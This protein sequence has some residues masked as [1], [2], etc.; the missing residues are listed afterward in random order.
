MVNTSGRARAIAVDGPIRTVPRVPIWSGGG[1]DG[2]AVLEFVASVGSVFT[3]HTKEIHDLAR[4]VVQGNL[5]VTIAVGRSA[6]ASNKVRS[7]PISTLKI[8]GGFGDVEAARIVEGTVIT[9][10]ELGRAGGSGIVVG[11]AKQ[12][13]ARQ[14]QISARIIGDFDKPCAGVVGGIRQHGEI[15]R[16][17]GRGECEEG[18]QGQ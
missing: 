1:T 10:V 8:R 14:I 18:G 7:E 12:V 15:C 17:G 3:D 9:E 16:L 2:V 6:V 11:P 13:P 4:S 5:V